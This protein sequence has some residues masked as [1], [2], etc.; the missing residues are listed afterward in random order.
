[1]CVVGAGPSGASCAYHLAKGGLRHTNHALPSCRIA[2]SS[3]MAGSVVLIESQRF[4]HDKVCGDVVTPMAQKH[5]EEM[6]VLQQIVL[7]KE[8]RW[9]CSSL[10]PLPLC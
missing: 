9:V 7:E 5:L 6:G 2:I 10:T 3:A 1:M 4:P 8:G